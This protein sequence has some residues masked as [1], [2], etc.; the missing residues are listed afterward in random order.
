MEGDHTRVD[1]GDAGGGPADDE[2]RV[3]TDRFRPVTEISPTAIVITDLDNRVASWNPAAEHLFGYPAHEAE[4]RDLDDLVA[5]TEDLHSEASD[6]RRRVAEQERIRT[7]ARRTRNDGGIVDVELLAEPLVTDDGRPVGTF[8]IY[9]DIT[10]LNRQRRFFES[11]LEVSPEAIVTTTLD[12]IVTSWNPA[13]E[14]L[15][16]D[17]A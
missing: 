2:L 13:A 9:H 6:Y 1:G 17:A 16:G 14:R 3:L 4:G 8:A 10:E 7:I 5:T 15:V 11:L 12:E